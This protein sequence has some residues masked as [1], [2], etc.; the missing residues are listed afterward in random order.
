[1]TDDHNKFLQRHKMRKSSF[2]ICD[3]FRFIQQLK[4]T[5]SFMNAKEIWA[6]VKKKKITGKCCRYRTGKQRHLSNV[7]I[8]VQTSCS[9][10]V[11]EM[12]SFT[13]IN[14]FLQMRRQHQIDIFCICDLF[15]LI[16]KLTNTKFPT[17]SLTKANERLAMLN[18]NA[19]TIDN[20][21]KAVIP[22]IDTR[23]SL[24]SHV[25]IH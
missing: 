8:S 20:G 1:M 13:R 17:I 14:K 5:K 25:Q 21:N 18:R 11:Q 6:T 10:N 22:L 4:N 7:N 23:R 15:R 3:L 2:C 16:N 24:M 19:V 9:R 12:I